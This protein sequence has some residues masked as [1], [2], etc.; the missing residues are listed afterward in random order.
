ML[1]HLCYIV[2]FG[3]PAEFLYTLVVA[4]IKFRHNTTAEVKCDHSATRYKQIEVSPKYTR[5]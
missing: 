4:V 3:V 2:V 5:Q 1:E